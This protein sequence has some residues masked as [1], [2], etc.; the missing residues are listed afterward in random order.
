MS[1]LTATPSVAH[2]APATRGV[3]RRRT[4]AC[5]VGVRLH[6]GGGHPVHVTER[7]MSTGCACHRFLDPADTDDVAHSNVQR[8]STAGAQ[9]LAAA[10]ARTSRL[11]APCLCPERDRRGAPA[12]QT[13]GR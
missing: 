3:L 9:A 11:P 12:L 2:N 7:L 10:L 5:S 13:R 8:R 6:S 1:G 4:R